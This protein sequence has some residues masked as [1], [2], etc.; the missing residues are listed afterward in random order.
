MKHRY[1]ADKT[2]VGK[3]PVEQ[4]LN[5]RVLHA[6]G[7]VLI[8]AVVFAG[9]YG[10][11]FLLRHRYEI[12]P[13]L[14]STLGITLPLVVL[15]KLV[16][17]HRMPDQWAPLQAMKRTTLAGGLIWL[18]QWG[19]EGIDF[20]PISFAVLAIDA[21]LTIIGLGLPYWF[22]FLSMA[23]QEDECKTPV[24][25]PNRFQR[26]GGW[27]LMGLAL[28]VGIGFPV[29]LGVLLATM[30][31]N[32]LGYDYI[33][34]AEKFDV[35]LSADYD[36][37]KLP[38]D[39]MMSGGSHCFLIPFLVRVPII[40]FTDWNQHIEIGLGVGL[41][42]LKVM[43]LVQLLGRGISRLGKAVLLALISGLIFTLAHFESFQ[44]GPAGMNQHMADVG[45]LGGC[46]FLVFRPRMWPVGMLLCGVWASWSYGSGLL[47]W[48]AYFVGLLVL[49][50]PRWRS[51]LAWLAGVSLST[52]PYAL[53]RILGATDQR[54]SENNLFPVKTWIESLTLP[55][56]THSEVMD[57]KW[58]WMLVGSVGLVL[59]FLA[60]S[61]AL[62]RFWKD[63]RAEL[64][65]AGLVLIYSLGT[66]W[67]ISFG[68]K[69]LAPWYG[70]H[71]ALIWS[72]IVGYAFLL[73]RPVRNRPP[74]SLVLRWPVGFGWFPF[75][76]S[77]IVGLLLIPANLSSAGKDLFLPSRSP[78]AV[79]ALRE[80]R[81]APTHY[82]Q[83]PYPKWRPNHAF[84]LRHALLLEKR[85]WSVFGKQREYLLQGDFGLDC[86]ELHE[87]PNAPS[88]RWIHNRDPHPQSF[89]DFRRLNL[90]LPASNAI[91]WE[92][93]IPSGTSSAVFRSAV[94][95]TESNGTLSKCEVQIAVK[96]NS[97]SLVW[98]HTDHS[99]LHTWDP[100][101]IS[102]NEYAGKTIRLTLRSRGDLNSSAIWRAPQIQ[103]EL[104]E[105]PPIPETIVPSNT[106]ARK[107]PTPSAEDHI[108]NL[109]PE[110]W[111][112]PPQSPGASWTI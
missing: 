22:R 25:Q 48:P 61:F 33:Y 92:I 109:S 87:N 53:H 91:T 72:A 47:C 41:A 30:G 44:F 106:D 100:C 71:F 18:S 75:V 45:F 63:Q 103:M 39:S 111:T 20:L 36:W 52:A 67:L 88:L 46:W 9:C 35:I 83:F 104:S 90:W 6:V 105:L 28:G 107:F 51:G 16:I 27:L 76:V 99:Q 82:A 96:G 101:D 17:F 34:H 97:P 4:L 102:L 43:L 12:P 112:I 80:F 2:M 59:G 38:L 13:E 69:S 55:F 42:A 57:K 54:L 58:T 14:L 66:M 93:A 40:L 24:P 15:I 31:E 77:S 89:T 8:R 108:L 19:L 21:V 95:T 23:S 37:R 29:R 56:F 60:V 84:H 49:Q 1:P 94:G 65:P 50:G 32:T 64:V 62:K 5:R 70:V 73:G 68:R 74:A 110:C 81:T 3:F 86:V 10:M 98:T 11:A 7:G 78:V 79:S 85:G 26:I